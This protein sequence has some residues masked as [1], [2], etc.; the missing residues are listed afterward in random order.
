M[1]SLF[2]SSWTGSLG[3]LEKT[4]KTL[5]CQLM[6]SLHFLFS[7]TSTRVRVFLLRNCWLIVAS[8]KFDVFKTNMLKRTSSFQGEL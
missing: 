2:P 7:Q 6:F 1:F 4:M 3:E 5:T 8:W